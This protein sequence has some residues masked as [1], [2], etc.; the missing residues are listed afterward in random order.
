MALTQYRIGHV[1][2]IEMSTAMR[3]GRAIGRRDQL[4]LVLSLSIPAIL[5]QLVGTAMSYIDTA[6]VGSIG[7]EAT[8]AIGVVAS[9]TWLIGGISGSVA[10]GFSVQV[11]QLLGAGKE[12]NAR[13]VV[14]ESILFNVIFGLFM[15]AV[16]YAIGYRLP[17]W[18]GADP[19]IQA[20]ATSYFQIYA[21]FIPFS[22]AAAIFSSHLR[23]SGNILLPSL[24][25]IGMCI[26]DVIFN[27]I[28]IYPT[29]RI[30]PITVWGAGLGVRGAAIGTGLATAVVGIILLSV[31]VK[32]RSQL[33]LRGDA[34]WRFS[35]ACLMNMLKLGTPSA[36]ERVTI[37]LAQI[38]MTAVVA[39][40]GAVSV[41]AN[42]VAVQ[43]EGICYLPAYGISSAATA[44][45][46]QSIGAGRKDMAKRFASISI[47]LAVTLVLITS[48]LLFAFAPALVGLL[49]K[50]PDVIALGAKVLRI[51]AF[52]EPLF[53]LSIVVTGALRGAGDSKGPFIISVVTMW[54]IRVLSVLLFTRSLGVVGVWLSMTVELMARGVIFFIRFIRGRWLDSGVH[55]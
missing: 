33:K 35:R 11:A 24:M 38:L 8:A 21:L 53:A 49:T 41:A 20:D 12:R 16:A 17:S 42:Y 54:G 26:L 5:E 36:L 30:G 3:E 14:V 46:G 31:T 4:I 34:E 15:A 45:V 32:G 22:L 18:L 13:S 6:M 51:V 25:N 48:I 52:A 29:R 55:V 9:T 44:M 39:S 2:M 37:S 23:C 50:E 47:I 27:F 1:N 10:L 40:M 43:T 28:F 7:Y 19:S